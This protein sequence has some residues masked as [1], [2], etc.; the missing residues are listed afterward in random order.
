MSRPT[1]KAFAQLLQNAVHE[2]EILSQ[3]YQQFHSYSIGNQLL[4]W[5]QCAERG[6]E[7]GPMATYPRWKE[8]GRQVRKGE[9]AITLCMPITVKRQ[10]AGLA[11]LDVVERDPPFVTPLDKGLGRQLGPVVHAE[12]GGPAVQCDELLQDP[13][14]PPGW[15]R[16]THVDGQTFAIALIDDRQG[17]KAASV[18]QRIR[19]EVERPRLVQDRWGHERSPHPVGE[20]GGATIDHSAAV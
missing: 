17:P 12:R 14:H 11:R 10:P 20:N 18:I 4:A 7:P 1:P 6:L 8:L 5:A 3:A 15:D 2:P 16:P 13:G 19:H 9:K